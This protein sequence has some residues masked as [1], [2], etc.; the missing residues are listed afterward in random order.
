MFHILFEQLKPRSQKAQHLD[1]LY[2]KAVSEQNDKAALFI[3]EALLV[4]EPRNKAARLERGKLLQKCRA[5]T[6]SSSVGK[7]HTSTNK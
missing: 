4:E 5:E 6:G 3:I 1:Q 2:D 7:A